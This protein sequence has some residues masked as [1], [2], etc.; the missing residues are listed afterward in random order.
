VSAVHDLVSLG[1]FVLQGIH[2][3]VNDQSPISA[4]T[5]VSRFRVA[6]FASGDV[7]DANGNYLY[8]G[9]VTERQRTS[10]LLADSDYRNS[11][12][13]GA[14]DHQ[15][16]LE[17]ACFW[18]L[19][20]IDHIPVLPIE[21]GEKG[22]KT[23][24]PT[25]TLT[26]VNLVQQILRK[27][28]DGIL[29]QDRRMAE[30]L[31]G[32]R[33]PRFLRPEL[34]YSQDMKFAT[35]LHPFWLTRTVYEELAE[36]DTRL[37][38]YLPYYDKLFGPRRLVLNISPRPACDLRGVPHDQ[39]GSPVR[40][41]APV[42]DVHI[43]HAEPDSSVHRE[44]VR[45]KVPLSRI[46]TAIDYVADYRRWLKSLS[47]PEVGPLTTRGAMMGDPTSFPVMPL[48]SAYAAKVAKHSSKDG[49]LTGDDAA[50]SGFAKHKVPI[51]EAAMQSLGGTISAGK[52][53]WHR[54]KA[55][56]CETPYYKGVKQGF[57]FLSTWVAPPGGS[58][59]E[60]NWVSQSLTAVQQNIVNGRPRTAGLWIYSPLWRSQQAA[61][62][63]GVPVGAPP[64]FGG[65]S[66]PKFP[67]ISVK[68][69]AQWLG[70]LSGMSLAE[71][72]SGSGLSVFPTPYQKERC[73][74]ATFVVKELADSKD[75]ELMV[76][77]QLVKLLAQ[78]V[79]LEGFEPPTSYHTWDPYTEKGT[80][81]REFESVADEAASPLIRAAM[82]HRA[83]V[84]PSKAPS[85]RKCARSFSR[86]VGKARPMNDTFMNVSKEVERRKN[87]Y[88]RRDYRLPTSYDISYGLEK[89]K[90][91][92]RMRLSHWVGGRVAFR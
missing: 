61:Y 10:K 67:K 30:G 59:G 90:P 92:Q 25:C 3:L 24:F 8:Q 57:F 54:T 51:Y 19:D 72:T 21:A 1:Y 69:H 76:R 88:V 87:I 70:Y 15:A 32:S 18:V 47:S 38:K 22:L 77:D 9:R 44:T 78:G 28:I 14:R 84:E 12:A 60:I 58:K 46:R 80:L 48:M 26:A 31:G 79:D 63:L 85:I 68:H 52:T 64:E 66:H 6:R 16:A 55:L 33:R 43:S 83:P 36:I 17:A 50:Y 74:A 23:R 39:W 45:G 11:L 65:A 27:S 86:R 35:D 34:F 13:S 62:L 89:T 82:Y 71:L 29:I 41:D 2:L 40:L 75:Q 91:L 73:L 42:L 5:D 4:Q 37:Q 49:M 53:E 7:P 81:Q 20:Q 56:F